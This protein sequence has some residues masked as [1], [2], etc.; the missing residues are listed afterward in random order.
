[1]ELSTQV[2][3][4]L[5]EAALPEYDIELE[6]NGLEDDMMPPLLETFNEGQ[7]GVT[8]LRA[9]GPITSYFDT[10]DWRAEGLVVA[11]MIEP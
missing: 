7:F 8:H 1:M 3:E 6:H 4:P 11:W 5:Q 2:A 9:R 10:V